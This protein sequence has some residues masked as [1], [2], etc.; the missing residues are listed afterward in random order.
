MKYPWSVLVLL[1]AACA[2]PPARPEP[3]VFPRPSDPSAFRV[4]LSN[5]QPDTRRYRIKPE[6]LLA[7]SSDFNLRLDLGAG[8]GSA[9]PTPATP[10]GAAGA[11]ARLIREFVVPE[12]W[13]DDPRRTV[14]VDGDDLVVR[15]TS[16]ALD[17]AE[18]FIE[19]L[20]AK[21]AAMLTL[22]ARF[23]SVRPDEL[24][25]LEHLPMVRGGLGGIVETNALQG[26]PLAGDGR[27]TLTAPKLTLFH[28]QKGIIRIGSNY[29]YIAGYEKHGPVYDPKPL[30][31]W[32][33]VELMAQGVANG[34]GSDR[35]LLNLSASSRDIAGLPAVPY[36]MFG[37]RVHE[38]PLAAESRVGGEFVLEPNQAVVLLA[39]E[40]KS[41]RGIAGSLDSEPPSPPRVTLIVVELDRAD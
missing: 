21:R 9:G 10:A 20:K 25:V 12:S 41:I 24:A 30:V 27:R 35:W 26:T 22:K 5:R 38:M 29:A 4:P 33:G 23:V 37:N 14:Y 13:D 6:E 2:S 11:V 34:P 1:A 39:P 28:A 15:H 40:V 8:D 16:E 36:V 18:R 32:C 3:T 17:C 31:E 7:D 19:T